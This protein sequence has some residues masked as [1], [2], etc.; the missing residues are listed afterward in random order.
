MDWIIED[1]VELYEEIRQ[2]NHGLR[3]DAFFRRV[4]DRIIFGL[5]N[6]EKTRNY[7]WMFH[8]K[9]FWICHLCLQYL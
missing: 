2:E 1:L 5:I 4:K 6:T 3:E 8:I 7:F 9:V